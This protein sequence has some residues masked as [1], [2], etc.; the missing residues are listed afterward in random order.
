[1]KK[2]Y[3]TD[4]YLAPYKEAIEARHARIEGMRRHIAGDGL[5]KDAVNNHMYYGLH[6]CDDGSWVF[7]EWAPNATKIYLVGDF[8]N[9]KR[10]DAY[11]LKPMGG[12]N[13]ELTLPAFFLQHGE[14]YKLYIEWP[15]GAGERLP[16]Y[17]TRAV[18]DQDEG[19]LRPG[20]GSCRKI[21]LEASQS[22]KK[23]PS[24]DLRV[25]YRDV[26]RGRE[27]SLI[28]RVPYDSPS[29]GEAPWI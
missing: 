8:N 7:R 2:I 15:G 6:R 23:A 21:C 5:L 18:Q 12:G 9:W 16:S 24:D 4:P 11:A 3:E 28:R 1:M 22:W 14:L 20:L 13:W 29:K 27:S 25:P 26:F 19:L 10:T 17:T